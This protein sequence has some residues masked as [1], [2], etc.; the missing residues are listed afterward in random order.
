MD[1]IEECCNCF[2]FTLTE[3]NKQFKQLYKNRENY[4]DDFVE[5][6]INKLL[7]ILETHIQTK[8]KNYNIET[9]E[10]DDLIYPIYSVRVNNN[11][12]KYFISD[13]IDFVIEGIKLKREFKRVDKQLGSYAVGGVKDFTMYKT[14][15]KQTLSKHIVLE[16]L[17][18]LL[19]RYN[20]T[21]DT[22]D[23]F[24]KS[25]PLFQEAFNMYKIDI[26][27]YLDNE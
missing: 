13:I 15:R 18:A 3:L 1:I 27:K 25:K 9:G 4:G 20:I 17:F 8:Y 10:G 6:T 26:I 7:S 23:D 5:P 16:Y 2:G 11:T 24:I 19:D 12:N 14:K 21:I 22:L